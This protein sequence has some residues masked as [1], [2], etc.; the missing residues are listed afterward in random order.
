MALVIARSGQSTWS[1]M[2]AAA[3]ASYSGFI[4]SASAK[5]YSSSVG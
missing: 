4:A 5:M 2:P 1:T 3:I